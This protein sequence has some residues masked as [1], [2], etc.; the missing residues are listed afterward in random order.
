MED[1]VLQTLKEL[2]GKYGL[3]VLRDPDRLAQFLEDMSPSTKECNF[4]ITFALRYLL[5]TGWRP[6]FRNTGKN[7]ARYAEEFKA[8]LGFSHARAAEIIEIIIKA[9]AFGKTPEIHGKPGSRFE[10]RRGSL[11]KISGGIHNAPRTMW[12][13]KK[14][15]YNGLVLVAVLFALA[16]L[17]MQVGTQ[18]NPVGNEY[19]IAYFA[20]M[21]GNYIQESLAAMRAA[22]LAVEVTNRQGGVRGY[23]LKI[24]GY[25]TPVSPKAAAEYVRGVLKDRSILMMLSPMDE[26]VIAA[27]ASIADEQQVPLIAS[28]EE[29]EA[30]TLR[31]GRFSLY[32]FHT[33]NSVEDRIDI[34]MHF[35]SVEMSAKKIALCYNSGDANV[36]NTARYAADSARQ[37]GMEVIY[38]ISVFY[39]SVESG[40]FAKL[41]E[42]GVDALILLGREKSA[43][44]VLSLARDAGFT[45]SII[46]EAR[47]GSDE[48][49]NEAEKFG[50]W[51]ISEMS[52]ADPQVRS[53]M[54]EYRTLYNERCPSGDLTKAVLAYDSVRW[55][56]Q[57]LY[58]AQG[59]RGEAVRHA[60]LTT[61]NF[62]MTHATFSIDPRTHGPLNKAMALSYCSNGNII[63]R[64]RIQYNLH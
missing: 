23:K 7:S 45:G 33:A 57:A 17:F 37:A 52:E 5:K 20:P 32:S 13:R 30:S 6:E 44:R 54:K 4:H 49:Y 9:A 3:V 29:I 27:L 64:K 56:A 22:Q 26:D 58:Q 39:N 19:R 42:S 61:R 59:I 48:S 36:K 15:L 24:V 16:T 31:G 50:S 21:T 55:I 28:T 11:R 10:A 14:T 25:D 62:P 12:I 1:A 43:G 35:V 47:M 40:A 51:L 2:V 38:K 63:F 34:I 46:T 8:N 41:A 60:L 18:R 53:V